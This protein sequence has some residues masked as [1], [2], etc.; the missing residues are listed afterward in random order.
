MMKT[1]FATWANRIAPVFDTTRHVY[2]VEASGGR[3]V[4]ETQETLSAD[5]PMQKTLRLVELG[6]DTLVCGA[7]S[8]PLHAL[9]TAYGIR[10]VPF[11]AG[12]LSEVMRAWIA[13]G[14]H[15]GVFAMPGCRGQGRFRPR[16]MRTGHR[17]ID[18][19]KGRGGATGGGR[20]RA[21]GGRRPQ[22]MG[23]AWAVGF[24]SSCL[25]P[26]C[27]HTEPHLPG[28]ICVERLCPECGTAMIRT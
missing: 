23:G 25:C 20:G 5:L 28:M 17:G 22:W 13:G 3:I 18:P 10:V 2:V 8:Q 6:V 7:I 24:T 1:A 26:K 21:R 14:L 16:G 4:R 19:G 27:G 11:V 9:V 15:E 12:E